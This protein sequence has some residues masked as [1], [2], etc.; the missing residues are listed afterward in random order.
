MS[1]VEFWGE[2]EPIPE[3]ALPD[4]GIDLENLLPIVLNLLHGVPF[5]PATYMDQGYTHYEVWCIGAAGGRGG[6]GVGEPGYPGLST[7]GSMQRLRWYSYVVGSGA[8]SVYHY[9]DPYLAPD[10][11]VRGGGGGGGGMHLV[12]GRLDSLPESVPVTVGQ[13]GAD[14]P[15]AQIEGPNTVVNPKPPYAPNYVVD[16]PNTQWPPPAPGGDGGYSSFGA[17]AK[18]SGGKGG[19]ASGD[20]IATPSWTGYWNG[21]FYAWPGQLFLVDG[22]GG[23]GG[24][25]GRTIAGGG[26]PGSESPGVAGSDGTWDGFV[27]KGGGGGQGGA[28]T[29]PAPGV[30][31][32]V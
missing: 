24:I 6:D 1:R 4:P 3:I 7:S 11:S 12:E 14:A 25:G 27:G 23:E 5:I 22:R 2:G 26:A 19:G 10:P 21:S 31:F 29:G 17:V 20:Y 15:L 28:N 8:S 18:A 32:G 9:H 13:A 16:T 30:Q